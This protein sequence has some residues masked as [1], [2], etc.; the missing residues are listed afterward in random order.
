MK[1]YMFLLLPALL[2]MNVDVSAKKTVTGTVSVTVSN[3]VFDFNDSHTRTSGDG[4]KFAIPNNIQFSIP[5]D[6]KSNQPFEHVLDLNPHKIVSNNP[7]K[8]LSFHLRLHNIPTVMIGSVHHKLMFLVNGES[9]DQLNGR[10]L[11]TNTG[12]VKFV[13]IETEAPI[14][15]DE[16]DTRYKPYSGIVYSFHS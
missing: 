14:T 3:N 12:V 15:V 16:E 5:L 2:I 6:I 8:Q 4:V 13:L 10:D 1:K 9:L 11:P 7:D